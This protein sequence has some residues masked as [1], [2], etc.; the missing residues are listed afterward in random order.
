LGD[1]AYIIG[2]VALGL[3]CVFGIYLIQTNRP[4]PKDEGRPW[5]HY[6]LLWP[7]ILDA[8]KDKRGGKQLTNREL[9]GWGIVILVAA[10][11]IA[12]T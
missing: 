8:D 7:L 2:A 3:I 11:A 9:I 10:V 5:F 4:A 12:I 1:Y 6:I